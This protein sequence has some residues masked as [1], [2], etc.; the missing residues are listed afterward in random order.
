MNK[1]VLAS[2]FLAFSIGSSAEACDFDDVL[3]G[4]CPDDFGY[5]FPPPDA[6]RGVVSV[7]DLWTDMPGISTEAN[8]PD[9]VVLVCF[10]GTQA[11]DPR[12]QYSV[13]VSQLGGSALVSAQLDVIE[14]AS[15]WTSLTMQ[16]QG[17]TIES[18]LQ[19]DFMAASEVRDCSSFPESDIRI[20]FNDGGV[21]RSMVGARSAGGGGWSMTL[22]ASSEGSVPRY[23][24]LHEFGHAVGFI[25]E[26]GHPGWTECAASADLEKMWFEGM[27][28]RIADGSPLYTKSEELELLR[29]NLRDSASSY[30]RISTTRQFDPTSIMT[31]EVRSELFPKG[32]DCSLQANST[33]SDLDTATFL[34][35]YGRPVDN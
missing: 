34:S 21:H 27:F 29:S 23:A 24:V 9:I 22:G 30:D 2:T 16:V 25:H 33:I 28:G 32:M 8:V 19:F 11:R 12:G 31:Y 14:I 20:M 15:E 5:T 7:D 18:R 35:M 10:F 3:L 6:P 1:Y 4:F 13:A 17:R 26:M